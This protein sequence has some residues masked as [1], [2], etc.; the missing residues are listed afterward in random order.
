M[1]YQLVEEVCSQI[2]GLD[3]GTNPPLLRDEIDRARPEFREQVAKSFF[4]SNTEAVAT[5]LATAAA[6]GILTAIKQTPALAREL[7]Q[8]VKDADEPPAFRCAVASVLCYLVQ[9]RDLISDDAPGGYGYVDDAIVV[10]AGYVEYL[11]MLPNP[12]AKREDED[13]LV[14]LLVSVVPVEAE[15]TLR[16]MIGTLR[17]VVNMMV[18]LEEEAAEY[19]LHEMIKNPLAMTTPQ[20]P[21]DSRLT[22]S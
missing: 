1:L 21:I 20:G 16:A 22:V 7:L 4:D 5:T 2:D 17:L 19:M 9:P 12:K 14:N 11:Q 15:P 3:I 8:V 13:E 10:R 6:L 18:G